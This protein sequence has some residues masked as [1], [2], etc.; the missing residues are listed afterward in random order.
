MSTDKKWDDSI[1]NALLRTYSRPGL[2]EQALKALESSLSAHTAPKKH[3]HFEMKGLALAAG[4]LLVAGTAFLFAVWQTELPAPYIIAESPEA[5]EA[6]HSENSILSTGDSARAIRTTSETILISPNS[7]LAVSGDPL[8]RLT[9]NNGNRYR[10]EKGSVYIDHKKGLSAFT[11]ET[12]WGTIRPLGTRL[13]CA[14]TSDG[15]VL[16]CLQ[17]SLSFKA[18]NHA[19]YLLDEGKVL[20]VSAGGRSV[21]I[22]SAKDDNAAPEAAAPPP[23]APAAPAAPAVRAAENQAPPQLWSRPLEGPPVSMLLL[24]DTA[25]LVF[26]AK[27]VSVSLKSGENIASAALD[28]NAEATGIFENSV[29]VYASGMLRAFRLPDLSERWKAETGTMAFTSFTI[30]KDRIYLPSADGSLYIHD[31]TDGSLVRK[32]T[33]GTG[34]YGKPLVSATTVYFSTLD[35]RCIAVDSR[36]GTVLW[37]YRSS[38]RFVDDKPF[39]IAE[40]LITNSSDGYFIGLDRRDGSFLWTVPYTGSL[41]GESKAWNG[42]IAFVDEE[43]LKALSPTGKIRSLSPPS[44]LDFS[45]SGADLFFA[46]GNGLAVIRGGTPANE[47]ANGTRAADRLLERKLRA[48]RIENKVLLTIENGNMLSC[49]RI[50]D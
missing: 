17:D 6:A 5:S 13:D 41:K 44:V 49:Y 26:P 46:D 24:K 8:R 42:E 21:I 9:G 15:L 45:T 36:D 3:F 20:T 16:H 19:E 30:E 29:I 34:L 2:D 47:S 50:P 27:L 25:V 23:G 38:R 18:K 10:L 37:E 28:K 31:A 4:I 32:I 7:T 43:G 48:A 40:V 14:L 1:Y 35:R 39:L 12:E 22:S 33:I 11:L